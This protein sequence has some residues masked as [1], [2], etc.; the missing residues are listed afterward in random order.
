MVLSFAVLSYVGLRVPCQLCFCRILKA[1]FDLGIWR[2]I[3][4]LA[5]GIVRVLWISVIPTPRDEVDHM[6]VSGTRMH[7]LEYGVRHYQFVRTP[8]IE[9]VEARHWNCISQSHVCP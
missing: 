6:A 8:S 5:P 9:P 1:T 2:S 3:Q 4:Q 7:L